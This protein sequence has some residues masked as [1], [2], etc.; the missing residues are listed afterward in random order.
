MRDIEIN[1]NKF[2]KANCGTASD[3][4]TASKLVLIMD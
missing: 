1:L 4:R 3:L 2:Q